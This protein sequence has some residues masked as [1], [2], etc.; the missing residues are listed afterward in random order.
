M[1]GTGV[2]NRDQLKFRFWCFTI[3]NPSEEEIEQISFLEGTPD[4]PYSYIC[5][6]FERGSGEGTK[7]VQGYIEFKTEK[8][9]D[10]VKEFIPRGHWERRRG[11]AVEAIAY[12]SKGPEEPGGRING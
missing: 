4:C 11:T 7:H 6:Q 3:N 1:S 12:C 2:T 9:F 8:R 10:T 5:W